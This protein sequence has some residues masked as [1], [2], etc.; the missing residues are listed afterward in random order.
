MPHIVDYYCKR[1]F[2]VNKDLKNQSR[3]LLTSL[4][5][6]SMISGNEE[7]LFLRLCHR[8]IYL[9]YSDGNVVFPGFFWCLYKTVNH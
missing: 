8:V 2:N 7:D 1:K 5:L 9:H 6:F 4:R 3:F